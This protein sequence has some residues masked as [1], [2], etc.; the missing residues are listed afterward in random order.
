VSTNEE[1]QQAIRRGEEALANDPRGHLALGHRQAIWAAL[2][3]RDA[4]GRVAR[5]RLAELSVRHVLPIW[6]RIWP[7]NRLP[8]HLLDLATRVRNGE[9]D[10]AT[11]AAERNQTFTD[12]DDIAYLSG[13]NP[14]VGVG[15]GA[16]HALTVAIRDEPFDP[17]HPDP[18]V[19]DEDVQPEDHD[20]AYYASIAA[21]GGPPWD[22]ESSAARRRDFW[23]WWLSQAVPA[24]LDAA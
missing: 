13:N 6:E 9:L 18:A 14:A 15:Y 3:P 11:L 17:A 20:S 5:A 12:L 4:A 23:Q 2:G 21:T 10:G 7:E 24:S 1:L 8:H 16:Q 22:E 19:R